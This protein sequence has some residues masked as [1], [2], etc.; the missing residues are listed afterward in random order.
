MT[1]NDIR[2]IAFV[3]VAFGDKYIEQ[4]VRLKES[5]LNIYPNADLFFWTG[6]DLPI[7]SQT[8]YASLYGFKPH[9]VTAA[10][11]AGFTKI[12]FFDPAVILLDKL[13]YYDDLLKEYGVLAVQD[14]TKLKT[15]I[16]K[17][18]INYFGID[19]DWLDGKNLVGGSFYY[20]D[21]EVESCKKI[22]SEWKLAEEKGVF[23]SQEQQAQGL[24][25][26]H[27]SDETVMAICL[28]RNGSK[29][30]PYS[31]SRYNWDANPI[32]DKKHFK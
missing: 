5:I 20:F 23:G 15:V 14:D 4:Q 24:I 8:F 10:Y 13:D 17:D 27:R 9:G 31:G 3:C 21:F 1:Q 25:G 28:Y 32:M 29:P 26:A 12:V 18:C 19:D 22:F 2:K 30:L 6:G 16:S 11:N 7:V